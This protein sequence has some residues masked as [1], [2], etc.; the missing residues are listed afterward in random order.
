[1]RIDLFNSAASQLSS[2][3]SSQQVGVKADASP[4]AK[5]HGIS[6]DDRTTLTSD[7]TSLASLV[8]AAL[9]SPEVRQG[10]VD[11]LRQA[12]SNGEYQV[13]PSSVAAAMVGESS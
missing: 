1:M 3:L 4:S 9:S 8:S 11:N 13:D 2:E 6:S 10:R 12:I 5:S 7:T